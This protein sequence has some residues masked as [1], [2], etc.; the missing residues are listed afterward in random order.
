MDLMVD[1]KRSSF[2]D[3]R[4]K[5]LNMEK[6][7]NQVKIVKV[8]TLGDKTHLD[9]RDNKLRSRNY[10]DLGPPRVIQKIKNLY[11]VV[12]LIMFFSIRTVT[13]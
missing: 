10:K 11:I 7:K 6:G 3:G 4:R 2:L 12:F 9:C 13:T 8:V 1:R 5:H